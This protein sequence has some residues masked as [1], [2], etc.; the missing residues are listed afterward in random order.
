MLGD[1]SKAEHIYIACGYTDMRKSIDGLAAI[2]QQ[3]F[4]LDPFSNSLFLFCGRSSTKMKVLYWEGDGFVLLYKRLENG[5][6]IWPRNK[7]EVMKIT[8][9]TDYKLNEQLEFLKE[10]SW[11]IR[12]NKIKQYI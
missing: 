4:K 1:I 11:D 5:K 3:N 12:Y 7:D 6:F 8:D 2:V 9:D 10:N